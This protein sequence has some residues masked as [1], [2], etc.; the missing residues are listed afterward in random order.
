MIRLAFALV[1][2]F[3]LPATA[4]FAQ[5]TPQG[6]GGLV[7]DHSAIYDAA[8]SGATELVPLQADKQIL[9]CGYAF[10]NGG[11][12]TSVGLVQGTGTAC[13]TGQQALTPAYTFIANQGIVDESPFGNAIVTGIGRAL[14]IKTG[15]ANAVQALV[16]YTIL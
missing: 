4:A 13:G 16:R 11:T 2:L 1:L 6:K 5:Y 10:L 8:A 9:V 3:L 7:C 14:C 12:A 15:G